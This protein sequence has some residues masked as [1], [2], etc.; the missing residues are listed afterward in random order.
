MHHGIVVAAYTTCIFSLQVRLS[1]N[2]P[3]FALSFTSFDAVNE[4]CGDIELYHRSSIKDG[5]RDVIT[6]AGTRMHATMPRLL[7]ELLH[8]T[9]THAH[10]RTHVYILSIVAAPCLLD[11]C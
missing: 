4:V 8:P 1:N 3:D 7:H 10:I 2:A 9:L 6:N 11:I 5:G